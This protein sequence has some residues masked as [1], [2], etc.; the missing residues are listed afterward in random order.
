MKQ[1]VGPTDRIIRVALGLALIGAS[2]LGYIGLWV[3]SASCPLP[4]HCSGSA[5][6]TFLSG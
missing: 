3:G 6:R 5:P 4:P 1:N 2:M